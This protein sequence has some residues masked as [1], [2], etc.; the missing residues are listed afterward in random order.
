MGEILVKI[1]KLTNHF[2]QVKHT[3]PVSVDDLLDFAQRN[4]ILGELSFPEYHDIIRDLA[5][6]GAKKPIYFKEAN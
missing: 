1:K 2:I 4:Y 3:E 5:A 6:R